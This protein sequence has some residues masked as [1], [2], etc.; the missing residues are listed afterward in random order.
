MQTLTAERAHYTLDLRKRQMWR[1]MPSLWR[2][3]LN[4]ANFPIGTLRNYIVIYQNCR[5]GMKKINNEDGRSKA[6]LSTE[7]PNEANKK[8]PSAERYVI[9]PE[10]VWR[11]VKNSSAMLRT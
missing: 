6:K 9:L 8:N 5:M 10:Q 7:R 1:I 4:H 11:F 2:E 3:M